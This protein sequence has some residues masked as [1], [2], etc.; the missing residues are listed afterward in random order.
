MVS[1]HPVTFGGHRHYSG[2]S[3]GDIMHFLCQVIL[4][5]HVVKVSREPIKVS[6]HPAKFGFHRHGSSRY[7]LVFVC[8]VISLDY[9]AKESSDFV[10]GSL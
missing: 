3:S 6:Q 2:Y 5:D 8:H 4:E 10:G 7:T 9:K 1:H